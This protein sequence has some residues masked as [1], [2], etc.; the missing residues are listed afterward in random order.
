MECSRIEVLLFTGGGVSPPASLDCQTLEDT[1]EA[2]SSLEV[3]DLYRRHNSLTVT[4]EPPL[5]ANGILK[6]ECLFNYCILNTFQL[7][8]L[9]LSQIR[10]KIHTSLH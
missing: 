3:P 7:P 1:P 9:K 5:V 4:W 6:R 10:Y 2:V 8:P